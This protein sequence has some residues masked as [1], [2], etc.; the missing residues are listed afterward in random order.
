M[1]MYV[2]CLSGIL[3]FL[4]SCGRSSFDRSIHTVKRV[5]D[6]N[7]IEVENQIYVNLIGIQNTSQ[8]K[9][10][11]DRNA[12]G[13]KI[14]VVYDSRKR[15]EPGR[16]N[17]EIFGYVRT[18]KK[19]S[20]NGE[21]LK[22]KLSGIDETYLNDSL[23]AFKYYSRDLSL[24][25]EQIEIDSP[26][27]ESRPSSFSSLIKNVEPAVFL[28]LTVKN[29]NVIGQ[30]TG[31]FI[32]YSGVGISN[33]HV[34]EGGDSW[35]IKY[36]ENSYQKIEKIYGYDK[37][38]DYIV[39]Q[40]KNNPTNR[41]IALADNIPSIGEEIFVIGNPTGLE[42]TV[43]KG[44]VSARRSLVSKDDYIQIDAAISPGSSGSPVIDMNGNVVAIATAKKP[45]CELCNFAL[46]IQLVKAVLETSKI[47]L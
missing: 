35:V 28:I 11:L 47:D 30:G 7:T 27:P 25:D 10:Y 43:T 42:K 44:I 24:K 2:I 45:D 20:I 22:Q 38:Y 8:S 26:I 40:V 33:Y 16:R 1:K 15:K 13:K 36:G 4:L 17:Q 3:L 18:L 39:F 21:V 9:K 41:I 34:F 37:E 6:G 31:F 32:S 14:V 23:E 5:V 46:N 19:L 29:D 12:L